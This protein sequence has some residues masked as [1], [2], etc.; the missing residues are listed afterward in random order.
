MNNKKL[1]NTQEG[2][3][4][5]AN[6]G[7]TKKSE[8]GERNSVPLRITQPFEV[9]SKHIGEES[10][11]G[12]RR[13]TDHNI[14]YIF[15]LT[16]QWKEVYPF[17]EGD[18]NRMDLDIKQYY[19]GI[20]SF[21]TKLVEIYNRQPEPERYK[22]R[23]FA[24]NFKLVSIISTKHAYKLILEELDNFLKTKDSNKFKELFDN[25]NT[26]NDFLLILTRIEENAKFS[27]YYYK[28]L[29]ETVNLPFDYLK[30]K[31]QSGI[32]DNSLEKTN[33]WI[34]GSFIY[35]G[36]Q[37]LDS[38]N[39]LADPNNIKEEYKGESK[40]GKS[41]QKTRT[42]IEKKCRIMFECFK[43]IFETLVKSPTFIRIF[44]EFYI[45]DKDWE[46][47]FT[48][49][50]KV[51][52]RIS[53][54][55]RLSIFLPNESKNIRYTLKYMTIS[56]YYRTLKRFSKSIKCNKS[57]FSLLTKLVSANTFIKDEASLIVYINENT[58]IIKSLILGLM[59]EPSLI[60]DN[61][62]GIK[63]AVLYSISAIAKFYFNSYPIKTLNK[64]SIPEPKDLLAFTFNTLLRLK[65]VYD[66]VNEEFKEKLV[67][68]LGDLALN[69]LSEN[70]SR[71]DLTCLYFY[72]IYLLQFFQGCGL[73]L[74]KRKSAE[75]IA[76]MCFH[77]LEFHE[78]RIP[79]FTLKLIEKIKQPALQTL[80]YFT[81]DDSEYAFEM[82]INNVQNSFDNEVRMHYC[83]YVLICLVSNSY[84][85]YSL[86]SQQNS[87][88]FK[89]FENSLGEKMQ[90]KEFE[91]FIGKGGIR[92]LFTSFKNIFIKDQKQFYPQ[93]GVHS[94]PNTEDISQK[95]KR[96]PKV[97]IRTNKKI[98]RGIE[99]TLYLLHCIPYFAEHFLLHFNINDELKD[100]S[101]TSEKCFKFMLKLIKA[102]QKAI[103]DKPLPLEKFVLFFTS[104]L[105]K[106]HSI[107]MKQENNGKSLKY[108]ITLLHTTP[109]FINAGTK[110]KEVMLK[111]RVL[112]DFMNIYDTNNPEIFSLLLTLTGLILKGNPLVYSNLETNSQLKTLYQIIWK[113]VVNSPF[114][115]ITKQSLNALINICLSAN[116]HFE[117]R[118]PV[119]I[120]KDIRALE[121]YYKI[122]YKLIKYLSTP[123]TEELTAYVLLPLDC[124]MPSL[125]N[126]SILAKSNIP[127]LLFKITRIIGDQ[128]TSIQ[129]FNY[130]GIINSLHSTPR[131]IKRI[132][133]CFAEHP[134]REFSPFLE[135]LS[136]LLGNSILGESMQDFFYFNSNC[137]S[138]ITINESITWPNAGLC[139]MGN[140]RLDPDKLSGFTFTTQWFFTVASTE[141]HDAK[142]FS[143]GLTN[144]GIVFKIT[145]QRNEVVEGCFDKV[146]LR[147]NAWQRVV[148]FNVS[149]RVVLLFDEDVFTITLNDSPVYAKEYNLIAIGAELSV[150]KPAQDYSHFF[151]GEM[152]ALC[153]MSIEKI[154]EEFVKLISKES[155][156]LPYI[157]GELSG[158]YFFDLPLFKEEIKKEIKN[159]KP[160]IFNPRKLH[161]MELNKGSVTLKGAK[162]PK[163]VH[164]CSAKKVFS[165]LGGLRTIFPLIMN[166]IYKS[167][168]S[169]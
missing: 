12:V 164:N 1:T 10:K 55:K 149:K 82:M 143:L 46:K 80:L 69:L 63:V 109:S 161:F 48:D 61:Y 60:E 72:R 4:D 54:K 124:L 135:K 144:K 126:I 42:M 38:L 156:L 71:T 43:T 52:L 165:N 59:L 25:L 90:R 104:I 47:D 15:G 112:A 76:K 167:E 162:E 93:P 121:Y 88:D 3:K 53:T 31:V 27:K 6:D 26:F 138:F 110:L 139:F 140:I 92:M 83:L 100:E 57:S 91:V 160:F 20:C 78:K 44:S 85:D 98:L 24:A 5:K 118:N 16:E 99:L 67:E 125:Y 120:I 122:I 132:M 153:F 36:V 18:E 128:S 21:F 133:R 89:T 35:N 115:S 157:D 137:D 95:N 39:F 111:E 142:F 79:E 30:N 68:K 136:K 127:H 134:N 123:L 62:E 113:K 141:S 23:T 155:N 166:Y 108:F 163:I 73:E 11:T 32:L 168:Y 154:S 28:H 49:N 129:L 131:Y 58:C 148:L 81:K 84:I 74:F 56:Y 50:H 51:K 87:E 152:S 64:I 116:F 106:F 77:L 94:S 102:L 29:F 33:D 151:K 107:Y 117:K 103:N 22:G 97:I 158:N 65:R 96:E 40:D 19:S 146:V 145:G 130:L 8:R 37:T 2:V 41:A 66:E 13:S 34:I 7:K 105:K 147:E 114:T 70:I 75:F 14:L 9:I 150:K 119:G 159:N 101:F 169:K 45:L 86:F 17:S